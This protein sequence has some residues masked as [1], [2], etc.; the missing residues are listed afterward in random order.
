MAVQLA[1]CASWIAWIVS[2]SVPIWFSLIGMLLQHDGR[3]GIGTIYKLMA[4]VNW[5][6]VR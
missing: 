3:P 1:W 4:A 6:L 5:A 2:V